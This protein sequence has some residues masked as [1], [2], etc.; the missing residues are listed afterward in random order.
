M[1]VAF[2]LDSAAAQTKYNE[3]NLRLLQMG[4]AK[5]LR[6]MLS[7]TQVLLRR[8]YPALW[9]M[10]LQVAVHFYGIILKYGIDY[11]KSCH[12]LKQWKYFGEILKHC[13]KNLSS[14]NR[15]ISVK[16]SYRLLREMAFCPVGHFW[17]HPVCAFVGYITRAFWDANYNELIL[18]GRRLNRLALPP[19]CGCDITRKGRVDDGW[20]Y[21]VDRVCNDNDVMT[22]QTPCSYS[23]YL[24]P[25]GKKYRLLLLIN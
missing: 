13:W 19:R 2:G 16:I 18:D 3:G 8:E 24:I 25:S 11:C 17:S 23:W 1:Y 10:Q 21:T 4:Q 15:K 20:L 6:T 9:Q 5:S 12:F 22:H 7:A 14:V